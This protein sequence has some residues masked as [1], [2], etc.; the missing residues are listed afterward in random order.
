MA[1]V[2][3]RN[4]GKSYGNVHISKDINLEINKGEFVVFVGPS[5][6]GK[7]TLLRMIAGLEDITA[8]ELYIGDKLM[9]DVPPA[10]R[11]IGMVFQSYA[12]YPHL[13]VAE[14]MSFGLKLAGVNKAERDQRVNQVAEI[15]QLAHLLDRKPK[16]LSGGQR[17]R[18]AIGRTLVSQPEV[19]LLDEPLSNL[20]AALRVQMRV[21]IS[22]LHKKL[23]RTMIYVTHDQVEAM[24][25]ADK[26]VVLNA[27]G[28]AQ[29]GKPLELYH[30]PANRFVAGFIGSPK[31]NFLPVKVVGVEENRV[32]IELP[33][34]NSNFWIPVKGEGVKIGDNLS[35]GIRPE[36]LVPADQAQVTL[37][38]KVQVVELLGNETQIHLEIPAIKQPALVYRQNDVVLVGEGDTFNIGIIPERC[39]LFK[40]DGTACPRLFKEKGI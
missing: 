3:L 1:N 26:I 11:G 24:T 12:L 21:E 38:G 18:V 40:E 9:N 14:N 13:D 19:F 36:H 22:K 4:V 32:Q 6:C 23:N 5:G 31:M 27:G 30:Y 37:Q 25:L 29:V 28:I 16:A 35:L 2:S 33:D 39:H 17:Q 8:G 10:K 34:A 7:S 15:L 20:D